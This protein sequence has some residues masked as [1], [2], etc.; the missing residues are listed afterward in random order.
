VF[1]IGIEKGIQQ[2]ILLKSGD[3]TYVKHFYY[4]IIV[5][6][7]ICYTQQNIK[8]KMSLTILH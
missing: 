2:Q 4:T 1:T 7:I 6:S 5:E 3:V 8:F